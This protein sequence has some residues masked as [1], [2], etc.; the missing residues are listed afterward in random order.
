MKTRTKVIAAIVFLDFLALNLYAAWASGLGGFVDY[1]GEMG[2]WG[3]VLGADLV[4]ALTMVVAWMWRDARKKGRNPLGFTILT[5][6]TGSLGPLLY[7]LTGK[8]ARA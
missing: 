4:I 7:L 6:A 1:L 2:P 5:I 3:M 8:D